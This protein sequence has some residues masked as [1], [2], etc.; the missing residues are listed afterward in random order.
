MKGRFIVLF[1]IVIVTLPEE[2]LL[3]LH[4]WSKASRSVTQFHQFLALLKE[5]FFSNIKFTVQG[6]YMTLICDMIDMC[7]HRTRAQLHALSK[8]WHSKSSINSEGNNIGIVGWA[9]ERQLS[10][11]PSADFAVTNAISSQ[12]PASEAKYRNENQY[13]SM[14]C[15]DL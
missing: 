12:L 13:K 2:I 8:Y 9:I 6:S 4:L 14:I 15:I 5:K 10:Y 11:I 1:V 7:V 3:G